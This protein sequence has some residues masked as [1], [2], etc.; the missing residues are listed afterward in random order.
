[1]DTQ[2]THFAFLGAGFLRPYP[3]W[4]E[5]A[6]RNLTASASLRS[7]ICAETRGIARAPDRKRKDLLRSSWFLAAR[8]S[9]LVSSLKAFPACKRRSRKARDY[10]ISVSVTGSV[11][12]RSPSFFTAS[13]GKEFDPTTYCLKFSRRISRK[14]FL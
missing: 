13:F 7:G 12:R 3:D 8:A 1:M 6:D 2:I 5:C 11:R 4:F 9:L 14:G 10:S